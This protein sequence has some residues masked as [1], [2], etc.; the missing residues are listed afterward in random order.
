MITILHR[1][2]TIE[3][4]KNSDKNFGVELDLR[5]FNDNIILA[6]EPFKNGDSFEEYLEH[7]NHKLLVLNIKESGIEDLVIKKTKNMLDNKPFFLLDIET[8]Y[9]VN[10]A[11]ANKENISV[12]YSEYESFDNLLKFDD[13]FDWIWIDTFHNLPPIDD[14]IINFFNTKKTCLVSPKRW[15]RK[16]EL[17]SYLIKFNEF[18]YSPDFVLI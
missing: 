11:G 16:N 3:N 4:L 2:N 7:Y 1:V 17:D 14:K 10:Q 8:P 12:R 9:I 6:H 13:F 15:G 5:C 18:N